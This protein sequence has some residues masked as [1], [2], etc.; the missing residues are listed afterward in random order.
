MIN[1]LGDSDSHGSIA[2]QIAGAI[3]G[4]KSL[5]PRFVEYLNRW[6]DNEVA[7]RAV[8]LYCGQE[9]CEES[10]GDQPEE[11]AAPEQSNAEGKSEE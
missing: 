3:Y 9:P 2:G 5:H 7:L 6:D 1:F 10:H 11:G 8:L 4:Y